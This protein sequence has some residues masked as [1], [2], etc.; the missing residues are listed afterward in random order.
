MASSA[1]KDVW[2]SIDRYVEHSLLRPDPV[3]D[4]VLQANAAAD[5]PAID[6]A[7]N[8]GKLLYLLAQM[9]G[10]RSVLEIGT[11]GGY[12]TIWLA[13]ALPAGGK[14]ITLES[15][16]K[17]ADVARANVARAGLSQIVD[18]RVGRALDTLPA[19]VGPFDLVFIDADKVNNAEYVAWALR[20][21]RMGS[22]IIVDNVVREG[23]ILDAASDDP[24]VRGTRK[25]FEA[26]AREPRL[27]A[28]AIQTVGNKGHDGFLLARVVSPG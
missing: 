4:A 22:A 26:I 18:V 21:T 25:L 14:I 16:P 8:Q 10:A 19:L 17:H 9:M 5:M 23:A 28:T 20:L 13:R 11:L 24:G 15:D 27:E 7:P 6:V 1:S 12:S 3:L 2:T